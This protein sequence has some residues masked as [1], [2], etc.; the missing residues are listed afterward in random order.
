MNWNKCL[1]DQ[2]YNYIQK[3]PNCGKQFK[4]YEEEQIPGFNYPSA[5]ICPYCD[6]VICRSMEFEFYTKIIEE[7]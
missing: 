1:E 4:V 6:R 3:C 7:K 5:M 2:E